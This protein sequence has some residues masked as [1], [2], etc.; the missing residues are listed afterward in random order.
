MDRRR[1]FA[2]HHD[3]KPEGVVM[4]ASSISLNVPA[5][6]KRRLRTLFAG[7]A[8]ALGAVASLS[9]SAAEPGAEGTPYPNMPSI[10]P[11]GTRI[12]KYFDVPAFAKGPAI[13]PQ[14]GYRLQELGRGLYLITD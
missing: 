2:F 6:M 1:H 11:I 4:L 10:A 5:S 3:S 8:L 12:D 14:K 9:V 13:D 7:I